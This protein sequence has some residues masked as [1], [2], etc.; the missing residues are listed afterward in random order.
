MRAV[1]L[2]CS[3]GLLKSDPPLVVQ[4]D[5]GVQIHLF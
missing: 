4:P 3:E 5:G 1:K 2:P